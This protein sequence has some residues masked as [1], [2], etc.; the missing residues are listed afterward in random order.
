MRF[1]ILTIALLAILSVSCEKKKTS[2]EGE[3]HI[4]LLSNHE[5]LD[6]LWEINESTIILEDSPLINYKD[7][8]H[9]ILGSIPLRSQQSPRIQ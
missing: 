7:I 9:M 3:I 2:R 4:Y 5:S 6:P 8:L 1:I